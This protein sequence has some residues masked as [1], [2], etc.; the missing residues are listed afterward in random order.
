MSLSNIKLSIMIY[1]YGNDDNNL[2]KSLS[3][4]NNQ[5]GLNSNTI[6]KVFVLTNRKA[7]DINLKYEMLENIN[8]KLFSY[9]NNKSN[10]GSILNQSIMKI[11]SEW[12]TFM[13]SGDLIFSDGSLLDFFNNEDNDKDILSFGCLSPI[14]NRDQIIDFSNINSINIIFGKYFR[15]S[16]LIN[17][18][19]YFNE[20]F[21]NYM[22]EDFSSRAMEISNNKL[23]YNNIISYYRS[24]KRYYEKFY[25]F[26]D[27]RKQFVDF[28]NKY[29][30]TTHDNI[31]SIIHAFFIIYDENLLDNR[32]ATKLS[33]LITNVNFD[34]NYKRLL[35][36]EFYKQKGNR[37][38]DYSVLENI[39]ESGIK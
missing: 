13:E 1:D 12:I 28:M 25:E 38:V 18:S 23:F 32:H 8:I 4:I 16:F 29:K 20:Q 37:N 24:S 26:I 5:V 36:E 14:K 17:N 21:T 2:F 15:K 33:E 27:Y 19:I 6:I 7:E 35:N 9:T 22:L 39:L 31:W 3:S 30:N 11:N 34:D 10:Y